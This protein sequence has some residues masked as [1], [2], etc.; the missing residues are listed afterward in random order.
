MFLRAVF[1]L[2]FLFIF[3]ACDKKE[4][5]MDQN[6]TMSAVL[7]QGEKLNFSLKFT[8]EKVLAINA[9][10]SSVVFEN[11]QKA[12]LFMFF[13]TWCEPCTA[14]IVSLNK[15]NEKYKD[16]FNVVGILLEDKSDEEIN[17][18]VQ[19][20]QINYDIATGEGNYLFAKSVG[21]INGVPVMVLF[22]SNAKFVKQYLGLIPEEMLDIDI[23]KAIM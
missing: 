8:N 18:F 14:Q 7:E 3:Q 12:T 2:F 13:T 19:E 22:D 9:E 16:S 11:E 17:A 4:E 21:G 5:P 15:L 20:K 23:Q 10:S 6:I 1:V